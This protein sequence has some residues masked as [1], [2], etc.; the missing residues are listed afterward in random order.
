MY[1]K[2]YLHI[3]NSIKIPIRFENSLYE[4]RT[5]QNIWKRWRT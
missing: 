2:L 1:I 5:I 3:K 4:V